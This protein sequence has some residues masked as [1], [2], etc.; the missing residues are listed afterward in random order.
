MKKINFII[1]PLALVFLFLVSG[2][3]LRGQKNLTLQ[4][5]WGSY[6]FWA[7]GAWG[8]HWMPDGEHYCRME[9]DRANGT[10]NI[11]AYNLEDGS[12]WDTLLRGSGLAY[13]GQELTVNEFEL[14]PSGR[15]ILLATNRQQIFRYSSR[16]EYYVYD[17]QDGRLWALF[18]GSPQKFPSFSPA[19]DKV[20]FVANNN[21]W[22][23]DLE[24]GERMQLTGDGREGAVINGASDW[25]YEEEL[26]LTKAWEWSPDG[27]YIA[28]LKFN[29]QNEPVYPLQFFRDS[30]YPQTEYLSY[31]KAGE[32][33]AR[34]EL[35]V[36]DLSGNRETQ[37]P[38]ARHWEYLARIQWTGKSGLL[39]YQ[40][41]NRH[42]DTL[43][44]IL[45]NVQNL[46]QKTLVTEVS[47]A[48]VDVDDDLAFLSDGESFLWTSDRNGFN[49]IYLG[50]INGTL[51][52]VTRGN[53][54][55]TALI[56]MDEKTG[57][58]YFEAARINPMQRE[59]YSVR[60]NGKGL[61]RISDEGGSWSAEW[62]PGF[63]YLRMTHSSANEPP[64]IQVLDQRL[65]LKWIMIDN[66]ALKDTMKAYRLG[67]KEFF[68][69]TTDEGT[70]LNGW[71]I[72]P[73]DFDPSRQYPVLMYVYGGPGSQTVLD[74]WGGRNYF[75]F[76]LLAEHGYIIASVDNRGTGARG[77]EFKKTVY[78][79]LGQL[80]VE[81]QVSAARYLGSLPWVDKNRIGIFGWSYG[82]YMSALCLERGSG[83]F[84]AGISV[85][86]VTHWKFYDNIYT[87]RF[88]RTPEENPE[89]YA[90]GSPL[91]WASTLR[92]KLLLVHGTG[93]DNVH[94][95]NS[96]AYIKA[97]VENGKNFE[98]MVYPD[99]NHGIPGTKYRFD[100]YRRMTEFLMRS[101]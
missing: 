99:K 67:R 8:L 31:P 11:I 97:L 85:A 76:Q 12:T 69:F 4:D 68:Q 89:G 94:F 51:K 63:S 47:S 35:Y 18:P 55:V 66:R 60:T 87:E 64:E 62:S 45:V 86:P 70:T 33:N 26:E 44:L 71:M 56:G 91:T 10:Y 82:G 19:E 101:L 7:E 41:L 23:L 92:G 98:L 30:T 58:I 53:W 61:K 27:R 80:E 39:T 17:R 88:M 15:K 65:T 29:T 81:D 96:A 14:S 34:V 52:P 20:A 22:Y 40:V 49:H 74:A 57:K 54:P 46:A 90:I 48:W 16:A 42:Q 78:L 75:W 21:L 25:V 37:I 77:N 84:R 2:L 43:Q 95:Q 3:S 36:A 6:T 72:K 28:Y 59:V 9:Y 32:P 100:L 38:V 73:P 79:R 1:Q 5:I 24:T 50:N 13:K 83:V 93:D